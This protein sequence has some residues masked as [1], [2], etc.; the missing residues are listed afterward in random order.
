MKIVRF[1]KIP[2]QRNQVKFGISHSG[3][4]HFFLI[5]QLYISKLTF[6]SS[7]SAIKPLQIGVKYV[8]K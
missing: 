2:T 5:L 7:K 3:Y 4:L 8:Q 1:H 6:A